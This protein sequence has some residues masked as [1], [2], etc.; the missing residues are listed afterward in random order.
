[1]KLR[2]FIGVDPGRTCGIA[3]LDYSENKIA[4]QTLM[5]VSWESAQF[6]LESVLAKYYAGP[7]IVTRVA[8]VEAF[9]TGSSAGT[10]GGDAE[11][12]RQ[13]AFEFAEQLQMWGYPVKI[14]KAA[15]I[16]PWATDKRLKAAGI[17]L[18]PE[19]RH[20]ADA[21][22]HALYCAVHDGYRMDPLK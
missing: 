20:A 4:G 8:Q 5:Q 22:R 16:K 7:N 13:K 17:S 12:T 21:A 11:L 15:D 19:M 14:R 10:K 1:M 18:P 6:V 2:S 9:I 3:M